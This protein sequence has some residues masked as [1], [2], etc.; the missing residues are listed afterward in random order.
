MA[1]GEWSADSSGY[2]GRAAAVEVFRRPRRGPGPVGNGNLSVE[3]VGMDWVMGLVMAACLGVVALLSG[4]AGLR[5][6]DPGDWVN[7]VG[8][9][10][11]VVIAAVG[12]ASVLVSAVLMGTAWGRSVVERRGLVVRLLMGR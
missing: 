9:W 6:I 11:V 3:E 7:W 5:G 4:V 12:L 8:W 1:C 2:G 10:V